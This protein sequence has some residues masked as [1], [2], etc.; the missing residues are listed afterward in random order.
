MACEGGGL[1][2]LC[3]AQ[4]ALASK[5]APT[6]LETA[7]YWR[8]LR[9]AVTEPLTAALAGQAATA[10]GDAA[11]Q[12]Q[13]A[14]DVAQALATRPCGHVGCMR[15]VGVSELAMRRGKRCSGCHLLRYCGRACQAADWP[16]HKAACRELQRRRAP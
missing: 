5:F 3:T 11:T 15:I 16:A 13:L 7:G 14:V 1:A 4:Q 9:A 2:Q 10:E 12:A 6:P 8:E